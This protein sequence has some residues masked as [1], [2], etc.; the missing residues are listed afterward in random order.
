L[1]VGPLHSHLV[2]EWPKIVPELY[3][4]FAKFSKS[5][6]QHFHMLEQQRKTPKPDEA[7]M[8]PCYVDSQRSY[9]KQVHIIDSDGCEP[10]EDWE[11][12]FGPPPQERNL[13]AFDQRFT[14]YS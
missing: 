4:K 13:R 9:P 7:P 14:Q 5:E 10:L 11:K 3:E 12:N 1:R 2:R 6:V 8:P